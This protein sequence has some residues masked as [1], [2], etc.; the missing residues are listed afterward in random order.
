MNMATGS[1]D[2]RPVMSHVYFDKGYM[3]A[4]DAHIL[5]K[6][7]VLHYSDFDQSEVEILNAKMIHKNTFKKLLSLKM[8]QITEEGIVDL[9]T[10]D[11]YKFADTTDKYPNYEAVIPSGTGPVSEIGI[12][13]KLAEKLMKTLSKI[14]SYS[15][16]MCLRAPN[17]AIVFKGTGED[18]GALTAM[19]M[20]VMLMD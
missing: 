11:V 3:I 14:G 12:N 15:L 16:R 5:I 1:D 2:L 19:I 10:K 20:P 13:P 17:E 6:A 18:S 7:A 4:T 9:A 8:V